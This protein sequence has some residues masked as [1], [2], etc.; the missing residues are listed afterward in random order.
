MKHLFRLIFA[1]ALTCMRVGALAQESSLLAKCLG[2]PHAAYAEAFHDDTTEVRKTPAGKVTVGTYKTG[3]AMIEVIQKAG[4]KRPEVINVYYY[5]EPKHDWKLAL[6][7][8]G[9]ASD[10]VIAKE[11]AT[12]QVHLKNIKAGKSL[13]VEA[14]FIPMGPGHTDGPELRMTLR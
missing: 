13:H 7:D 12:H 5:Q 8:I 9:I 10:G 1:I 6:K 3:S 11:D 14:V 4:T 2:E